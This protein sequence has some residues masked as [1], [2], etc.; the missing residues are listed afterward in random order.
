MA[1]ARRWACRGR[2]RPRIAV[3]SP[4]FTIGTSR[5]AAK[6]YGIASPTVVGHGVSKTGR[7]PNLGPHYAS[8]AIPFPGVGK[9]ITTAD[10]A[11]ERCAPSVSVIDH[12]VTHARLPRN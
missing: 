6:K 4:G 8:A 1:G 5:V 2:K 12:R 9:V 3:P 10:S 7:W 11:A